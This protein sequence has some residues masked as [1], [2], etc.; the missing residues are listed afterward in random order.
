MT[1]DTKQARVAYLALLT[2][3]FN[4]QWPYGTVRS[5]EYSERESFSKARK[6]IDD[7]TRTIENELGV[8][9]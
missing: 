6:K 4:R 3:E 9:T 5:S 8:T 1:D 7:L 2:E